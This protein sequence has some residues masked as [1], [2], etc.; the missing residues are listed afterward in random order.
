MT[1]YRR[2]V[3]GGLKQ[4]GWVFTTLF[5]LGAIG[6]A[7]IYTAASFRFGG[8]F[9]GFAVSVLSGPIP[10]RLTCFDISDKVL[11]AFWAA[12]SNQQAPLRRA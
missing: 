4:A 10:P 11:F 2:F 9:A 1:S 6:W 8:V 12:L 3:V 7:S 5:L